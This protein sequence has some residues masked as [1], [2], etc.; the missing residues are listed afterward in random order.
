LVS[1]KVAALTSAVQGVGGR[2]A[3]AREVQ[4][5]PAGPDHSLVLDDGNSWNPLG[6]GGALGTG[7][8]GCKGT[9]S[10]QELRRI[11]GVTSQIRHYNRIITCG[12]VLLPVMPWRSTDC[13]A[14]Y[15]HFTL[16]SMSTSHK[17]YPLDVS[18]EYRRSILH[19]ASNG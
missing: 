4:G 5:G 12:S 18:R 7:W 6:T 16:G 2:D 1:W 3:S 13:R 9:I 14:H 11:P 10:P 15:Q 8:T 19:P 17:P